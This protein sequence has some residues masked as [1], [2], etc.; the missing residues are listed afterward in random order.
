MDNGGIFMI[1]N[2]SDRLIV[3]YT[4]KSVI[5]TVI[6][7]L[8]LTYIFS[9]VILKLDL[10][11]ENAGVLSIIIFALSSVLISSISVS[12][13]KNNGVFMGIISQIPLILY[14]AFN[15]IFNE[16]TIVLFLIKLVIC[17]LISSLCGYLITNRKKRYKV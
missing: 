13:L 8:L 17:V 6:S 2:K 5:T 3:K 9:F 10:S 4:L 15:L 11:T 16:N 14:S 12:G 1:K 7:I